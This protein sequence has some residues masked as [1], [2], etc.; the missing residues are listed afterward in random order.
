MKRIFFTAAVLFGSLGAAQAQEGITENAIGMRFSDGSDFGAE[1]NYQRLLDS[2]NRLELGLGF[3][4]NKSL[5]AYKITG[6]YQ[7][8][9]N[10]KDGLHWYAGVGGALGTWRY[11]SK[12]HDDN[13]AIVALTGQV[14]IE[15]NFD[16][17]LQVFVDFR[18]NIY[19]TDYHDYNSFDPDFGIGARFKF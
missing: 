11:E 8:L 18:P 1:I 19:L 6:V 4:N 13:G 16:F 12:H 3:R 10:I 7:W 2:N 14:G 15:Y 17:P 5:D 9:W